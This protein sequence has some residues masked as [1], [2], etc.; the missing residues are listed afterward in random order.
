MNF[1][2]REKGSVKIINHSTA[3]VIEIQITEDVEYEQGSFRKETHSTWMDWST[4]SDL[5]EAIKATE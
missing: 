4:F 2:E 5:K 3:A 1:T